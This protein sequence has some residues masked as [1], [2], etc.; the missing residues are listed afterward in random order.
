MQYICW[1]IVCSFESCTW[2]GWR[3]YPL[4][5][6]LVGIPNYWYVNEFKDG[7]TDG[8]ISNK[9]CISSGGGN[10]W[11]DFRKQCERFDSLTFEVVWHVIELFWLETW[12]TLLTLKRGTRWSYS[13]KLLIWFQGWFVLSAR[14]YSVKLLAV[15][16]LLLT[17][18]AECVRDAAYLFCC[19]WLW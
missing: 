9:E 15:L 11:V 18:L 6:S 17:N 10:A 4:I 19:W 7:V 8:R 16:C 12:K 13:E 14:F 3:K 1:W 2:R 5:R